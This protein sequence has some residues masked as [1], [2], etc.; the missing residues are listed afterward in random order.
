MGREVTLLAAS[1][2]ALVA[3][4]VVGLLFGIWAQDKEGDI[5]VY[6]AQ[7]IH[8]DYMHAEW[9]EYCIYTKNELEAVVL[10]LEPSV[11]L[12]VWDEKNRENDVLTSELYEKYKSEELFGGFPTIVADEKNML[13]GKRDRVEIKEWICSQFENKP[14]QCE[15]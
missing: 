13:V 12:V 7:A 9:C 3:F 6:T 10:E 11:N 5:E 8:I 15:Q 4:I 2:I 1:T 14:K